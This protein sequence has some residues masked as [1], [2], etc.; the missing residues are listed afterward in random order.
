M[1]QK[2]K[3]LDKIAKAKTKLY[4]SGYTNQLSFYGVCRIPTL[5]NEQYRRIEVF[6]KKEFSTRDVQVIHMF[7]KFYVFPKTDTVVIW[8]N[9]RLKEMIKA[10]EPKTS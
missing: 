6:S 2:Q 1:C 7:F 10:D 9:G 3:N 4:E 5:E 8:E